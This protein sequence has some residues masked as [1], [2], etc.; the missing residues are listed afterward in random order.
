MI[1]SYLKKSGTQDSQ[2]PVKSRI[3]AVTSSTGFGYDDYSVEEHFEKNR[4][5]LRQQQSIYIDFPD[6]DNFR[7]NLENC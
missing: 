6:F 3:T 7:N 5:H 1:N 4:T 2:T